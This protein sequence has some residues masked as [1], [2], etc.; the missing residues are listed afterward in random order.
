MNLLNF[1]RSGVIK[2][3][4]SSSAAQA[5]YL[6]SERNVGCVVIA[7]GETPVGIITDRDIVVRVISK[8]LDPKSTE[9]RTVMT[10][11]PITLDEE[12]DLFE[13]LETMKQYPI[14]RFP[15]V[16]AN[17]NLSGFFSLDDVMYLLGIEMSAVS[18]IIAQESL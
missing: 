8:D 9:I 16:D 2:L 5:A 11:D 1:A 14:R 13:A 7:E 17:G 12:L 4:P 3:S 10:P 15:I 6:M 18:R